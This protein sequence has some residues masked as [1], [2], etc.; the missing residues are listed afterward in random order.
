MPPQLALI[1]YT[2]F[3]ACLLKLDYNRSKEQSMALWIP[4]LWILYCASKNFA[5]WFGT[6]NW[7]VESMTAA[8]IAGSPMDRNF[9][10]VLII[11]GLL[12]LIRRKIYWHKIVME[13][14]WLFLIFLYML[15][16][17]LWSDYPFVSLKR[18]LRASG[19]IVMALVVLTGPS[20]LAGIESIFRRMIYILIPFSVLL[21]KY[22]PEY[23]IDFGRWTGE[24][25]WTG[26]AM[27]K[28][29]LGMLCVISAL[30]LIWTW[31][32]RR[33]QKEISSI[34]YD[35]MTNV[36]L[37]GLTFWLLKGPGGAFSATSVVVLII[38]LATLFTLRSLKPNANVRV[39]T[40]VFLLVTVAAYF[41]IDFLGVITSLTGRGATLTGR[42]DLIWAKLIPIALKHPI[43]GV[44]YGGFWMNPMVLD[45]DKLMTVNEAHNGYLDVFIELGTVGLILL[46][47]VIV[48][49][50]RKA[51]EVFKNDI[52]WGSFLLAILLMALLHNITESSLLKST[53]LVWNV[54]VLLI[55]AYP[56]KIGNLSRKVIN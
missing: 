39:M 24:P 10:S 54:L 37:L 53:M 30:F 3:V 11:V 34:K 55:V 36:V 27:G 50:F 46:A 51:T 49:F 33:K 12:I 32:R 44:G 8:I 18:W 56:G 23:G 25:M 35:T 20:P 5:L 7:E 2:G 47:M 6:Y 21:V 40:C 1:L 29:E 38:G 9:L 4:T 26:V 22:Y 42:T 48:A 16:S 43:L 14:H 52:E 41:F 17:I 31:V 45:F 28:N 19:T 15:V 13:N